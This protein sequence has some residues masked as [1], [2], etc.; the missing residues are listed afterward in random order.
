MFGLKY[1]FMPTCN[2]FA[3]NEIGRPSYRGDQLK[4]QTRSLA[5]CSA[6]AICRGTTCQSATLRRCETNREHN[7]KQSV[8]FYANE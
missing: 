1:F 6:T 5:T 3:T 4:L 2:K 7:E 8:P